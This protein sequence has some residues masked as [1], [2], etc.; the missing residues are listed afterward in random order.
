M[1]CLLIHQAFAGPNEPG[2]TRHYEIGRYLARAGHRMTVIAASVSY[3]TGR[4]TSG[5]G[6]ADGE[7]GPVMVR[8][9]SPATL[10][11]SFAWR[12]LAFLAFTL[13][14][15]VAGLRVK[16]VDVV[17]GTSPPIFQAVSAWGVALFKRVPFVL[18]VR[19]L[20]PE[21]AIDMGVLRNPILIRLARWL[22]AFLYARARKIIVNSPAYRGY[23]VGRGVA[24]DK[25]VVIPNGVEASMFRPED[26]GR[27][28]RVRWGLGS[29]E[30]VA[31]YAGA[32]GMANDIQTILGA[33]EQLGHRADIRFV[34]VGDGK[35][36][37]RLEEKARTRQLANVIFAGTVPKREMPEAL[38]AADICLAT[39]LPIRMF[40]TTYPNKV[41]DYMAAGRPTVLAIDG[42]IREVV[43]R[44]GG[45]V[46]V[47][48]GNADELAA[49]VE[50]L[51]DD[52]E[53]RSTMGAA[54]R[55]Y[56]VQHFD[57]AQHAREFAA[58]LAQ[59]AGE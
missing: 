31:M 43:E 10:H 15:F 59:A 28:F 16:R 4:P 24:G 5:G 48:P 35:E 58:V 27:E 37:P 23:L 42:V 53:L 18:E 45:G 25:V 9:W 12:V 41:F 22:G 6:N 20:W 51:A 46:F 17:L 26:D 38:A 34:L 11:R 52:P 13:S 1:H 3:L 2:G 55:R 57:R 14:S 21:F 7:S 54:A 29:G 32:L 40:T 56:V 30:V 8:A 44:A 50:K 39:L 49:A 47:P 36:R 33:A 19:D